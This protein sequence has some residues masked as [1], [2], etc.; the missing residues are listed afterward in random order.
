MEQNNQEAAKSLTKE[1]LVKY[2]GLRPTDKMLQV[3]L[4]YSLAKQFKDHIFHGVDSDNVLVKNARKYK[5]GKFRV[6]RGVISFKQ[7]YDIIIVPDLSLQLPVEQLIECLALK[8]VYGGKLVM[9]TRLLNHI[10]MGSSILLGDVISEANLRRTLIR[11]GLMVQDPIHYGGWCN[12][13]RPIMELDFV[14]AMKL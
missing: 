8:L 11:N 7:Q 9:L 14:C 1:L 10:S 2:A 6:F 13:P 4:K 5:Q 3:G 12:G